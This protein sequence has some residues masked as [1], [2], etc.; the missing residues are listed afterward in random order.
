MKRLAAGGVPQRLAQNWQQTRSTLLVQKHTP[1]LVN[2]RTK[3]TAAEPKTTPLSDEK[4]GKPKYL[5]LEDFDDIF[6]DEPDN[7]KSSSSR[8]NTKSV[9]NFDNIDNDNKTS[10]NFNSRFGIVNH[11]ESSTPAMNSDR[12]SLEMVKESAVKGEGEDDSLDAF[13]LHPVLKNAL[14]RNGIN[15]FFPVQMRTFEA[16]SRGEDMIV[17]SRTG[18]GKTLAFSLPVINSLLNL[19]DEGGLSRRP[20][21]KPKVLIMAPTRELAKQVQSEFEKF[22][23]GITCVSVYGGADI[24]PQI[25]QLRKPVDVV[26]GTP[27]RIYDHINSGRLDL[28]DISYAVLDEADEMLK[29]GFKD[30]IDEIYSFMPAK[31]ERQNLLFSA[32]VAPEIRAVAHKHL[33]QGKLID[34]VGEDNAKIPDSIEMISMQVEGRNRTSAIASILSSHCSGE[35]PKRALVF[36]ATKAM[37]NEVALSAEIGDVGV[38]CAAMHGDL[39]Q[40]MREATLQSFREGRIQCMVATDVAARGLDIPQVDLVIHY[41]IPQERDSFVHRTGRT[42]RAGRAGRNIVIFSD[43]DSRELF[44]LQRQMGIKFERHAVPGS[45]ASAENAA[46]EME[47]RLQTLPRHQVVSYTPLARRLLNGV[48]DSNGEVSRDDFS[49][50]LAKA[51]ALGATNATTTDFSVITGHAGQLTLKFEGSAYVGAAGNSSS[52]PNFQRLR[53]TMED[54]IQNELAENGDV[55]VFNRTSIVTAI[56]LAKDRSAVFVD[57]A[58]EV[59]SFL[60][61]HPDCSL[62]EGAVPTMLLGDRRPNAAFKKDS[63]RRSQRQEGNRNPVFGRKANRGGFDDSRRT[64]PPRNSR[65]RN[66]HRNWDREDF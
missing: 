22:A 5:A 10:R 66:N 39:S 19:R 63:N 64:P 3:S 29:V 36:C 12:T 51:L 1:V 32:T 47:S 54:L 30:Q 8:K 7:F 44:D 17:R 59:S 31:T 61:A 13:G 38:K 52:K 15:K 4:D 2:L 34:L 37:C 41:T 42:G 18:S 21:G 6:D 56:A 26:I 55:S 43:R 25:A 20:A 46:G 23:P 9:D 11:D 58:R 60:L 14:Q 33:H 24:G 50:L 57:V 65:G 16:A 62:V 53:R 28:S 49:A 45:H 35:E 40:S 48:A 27:G